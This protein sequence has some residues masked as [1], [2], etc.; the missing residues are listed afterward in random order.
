MEI[1]AVSALVASGAAVLGVPAA[2]VVGMRQARAARQAAELAAGSARE[3]WRSSTRREAAVTFVLEIDRALEEARKLS[4][5]YDVLDLDESK[6]VQRALWRAMAVVRIEGPKSLS[7]VAADAYK[8]VNGA[9][10]RHLVHHVQARPQFLIRAAANEG[11]EVADK[12]R[13]RLALP[14][15][16]DSLLQHPM[17]AELA[18]SGILPTRELHRLE[19]HLRHSGTWPDREAHS[20]FH[21]TY[22]QARGK[23][24]AFIDA[25]YAHFDQEPAH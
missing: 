11:S 4:A 23:I 1:E 2:L 14:T 5:S 17:W 15:G 6:Q 18:A 10:G 21:E 9:L 22:E 19:N 13:K 12:V 24:D 16:R 25:V 20:T 7:D 8:L 3:Q